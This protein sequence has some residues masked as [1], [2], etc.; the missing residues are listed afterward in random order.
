MELKNRLA[1]LSALAIVKQFVKIKFGDFRL[2]TVERG[3]AGLEKELFY[4]L[5]QIGF[6]RYNK[7]IRLIGVGVRFDG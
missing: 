4:D 5:F 3:A 7:A 2:T 6:S 1:S